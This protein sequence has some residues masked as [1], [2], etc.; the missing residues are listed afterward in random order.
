MRALALILPLLLALPALGQT[1]VKATL[2]SGTTVRGEFA[3][4]TD[5]AVDA[6]CASHFQGLVLWL[7]A[8]DASTLTDAGAGA[9]SAWADKAQGFGP[10]TQGTAANRP[11]ITAAR[12]NGRAGL[13][14]DGTDSLDV[15]SAVVSD[16]P[17]TVF[18]VAKTSAA[19]SMRL[20]WVGDKDVNNLHALDV[21][22]RG[23]AGNVVQVG[24]ADGT[25]FTAAGSTG[26]YTNGVAFLVTGRFVSSTD[27][28]V[29]LN[30][31]NEGSASTSRQP[32]GMDRTSIGRQGDSAPGSLFNGDGYL[33][34]VF[35]V[36]VPTDARTAI[37][38]Y[39][40]AAWGITVP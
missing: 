7:D 23:D 6:V 19:S 13:V 22:V 32:A 12:Q 25:A 4:V 38:R 37:Q 2:V 34:L 33:V 9:C 5:Q 29:L 3:T 24:A 26:S 11:T 31:A 16:Y 1:T 8:D 17:V 28:R 21:L 39:I 10:V 18:G 35:N 15:D 20:W 40:G 30:G 27:R 36:D 14:F